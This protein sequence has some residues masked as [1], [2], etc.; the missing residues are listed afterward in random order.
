[1]NATQSALVTVETP[2]VID[3]TKEVSFGEGRYSPVMKELHH[4]LQS[5]FRLPSEQAEKIARQYGSDFG[6]ALKSAPVKVSVGK[7]VNSDGKITLGESC[8]VKGITVTN[9]IMVARAVDYANGA[10][11]YGIARN[12]TTWKPTAELQK[13]IDAICK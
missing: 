1:M 13:I 9:S 2:A 12:S 4:D 11:K 5:I 10:M 8:K 6:A 3:T 7:T